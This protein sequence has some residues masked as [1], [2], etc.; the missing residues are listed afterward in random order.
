VAYSL[1]QLGQSHVDINVS[2]KEWPL[3]ASFGLSQTVTNYAGPLFF[4]C[5]AMVNF[6]LVLNTIVSE[7]ELKLRHGMQVMGLMPSVYWTSH[8]LLNTVIV[9]LNSLVTCSFGIAFG[10][11]IFTH[12]QFAV[13]F[14][15]FFLFSE[16]MIFVA[17]FLST[18]ARTTKT[19]TMLGIF[20]L[21]IGLLFMYAVFARS[22]SLGY[23]WWE[24]KTSPVSWI[25]LMFFPPFNFGKLYLDI[26]ILASGTYDFSTDR[27]KF[28]PG[29]FWPDLFVK[30]PASFLPRRGVYH[31][32]P[33]IQSVHFLIMNIFF[34]GLLAWYLDN[35]I[36]DEYGN[37]KPLHFFLLPSYWGIHL[38]KSPRPTYNL[39]EMKK[40]ANE[41]E[42][43][44]DVHDERLNALDDSKSRLLAVR[45]MYLRKEYRPL[46]GGASKV[47]VA[48]AGS[49]W[50]LG[51]GK[52]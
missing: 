35:V 46:F 33:P 42:E 40:R 22:T 9:L 15:L 44:N 48:V 23:I 12:S 20:L 2:L 37:S 38:A 3:Y 47:N 25:I 28:G 39:D 16:T 14:L 4:F 10:F 34:Y 21:M 8:L 50:T 26:S 24:Q 49:C 7:K 45:L 13:K 31:A 27:N 52:L 18:L 41:E 36:P 30:I 51:E 29:F 43:D 6:M 17:F 32:P 11:P 19:A 1:E 5:S